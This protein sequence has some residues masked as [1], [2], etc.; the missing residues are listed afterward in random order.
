MEKEAI[1][2]RRLSFRLVVVM[3]VPVL[4]P[5]GLRAQV[6]YDRLLRATQEPQNW[7]TYSGDYASL[8]HSEI[9]R[10]HV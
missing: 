10:A 8:R 9:G 1:M 6:T 5:F 2:S 7:L 4:I 3:F